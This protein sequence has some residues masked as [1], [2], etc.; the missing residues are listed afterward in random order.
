MLDQ[1]YIKACEELDWN[2]KEC[3]DGTVELQQYSPAGEDFIFY[4]NAS[5]F[6][7][8]VEDYYEGFD[9]DEHITMWL[10]AKQRGVGG[11]PTARELVHDAEAIDEMLKQ[12]SYAVDE[13][14][15]QINN[16]EEQTE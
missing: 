15:E 12:L 9:V 10:E 5:D 2:V 16:T 13:V 11:V 1:R 6:R 8:E 14:Y 4:V 7:K 3:D